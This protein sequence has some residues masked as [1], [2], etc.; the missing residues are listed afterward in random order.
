MNL[1]PEHAVIFSR[2]DSTYFG[3]TVQ[4][5]TSKLAGEFGR[6]IVGAPKSNSTY[7]QK[8]NTPGAVFTCQLSSRN[9]E[10][11]RFNLNENVYSSTKDDAFFGGSIDVH[12]EKN[13]LLACAPRRLIE[14]K[15][16]PGLHGIC[17]LVRNSEDL[18]ET[19]AIFT[20]FITENI[21]NFTIQGEQN[22]IFGMLSSAGNVIKINTDNNKIT[23]PSAKA[24]NIIRD[25]Y[26]GYTV[27]SAKL[28]ATDKIYFLSAAPRD[29][30]LKGK[31]IIFNNLQSNKAFR[32]VYELTGETTGEYFGSAMTVADVNGDSF[33][34]IIVGAPM[35][36][37]EHYEDRGR[38]YVFTNKNLIQNKLV[39]DRSKIQGLDQGS[40]FGMAISSLGDIN[41][42]GFE[43]IVVGAPYYND[44]RGVIYVYLGSK[45]GLS[46]DYKQRILGS[47]IDPGLRGFGYSLSR[48]TDIDN[49][50]YN[51][52]AVG[53]YLS[54]H[55]VLLKSL[56]I[57]I[58]NI[59]LKLHPNHK[60]ITV[61]SREIKIKCCLRYN[62]TKKPETLNVEVFINTQSSAISFGGSET[63]TKEIQYN[64]N[65]EKCVDV[66]VTVKEA[67]SVPFS[68]RYKIIN[69]TAPDR[70]CS[71]CPITD[72]RSKTTATLTVPFANGCADD[73]NCRPDLKITSNFIGVES[74]LV[75]GTKDKIDVLINISNTGEN[76]FLAKLDILHSQGINLLKTPNGCSKEGVYHLLCNSWNVIPRD[77]TESLNLLLDISEIKS[78]DKLFLKMEVL[79]S[80]NDNDLTNNMAYVEL[81]L[82]TVANLSLLG[83]SFPEEIILNQDG[84]ELYSIE[85]KYDIKNIG[86][87][88]LEFD[89]VFFVPSIFNDEI[90][91]NVLE[92][93]RCIIISDTYSRRKRSEINDNNT[94][95]RQENICD[96][97]KNCIKIQCS[98]F[99]TQSRSIQKTIILNVN[100]NL[101][102]KLRQDNDFVIHSSVQLESRFFDKKYTKRVRTIFKNPPVAANLGLKIA[103]A[104]LSGIIG[105]AILIFILYKMKFFERKKFEDQTAAETEELIDKQE[106]SVTEEIVHDNEKELVE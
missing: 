13:N 9:C 72:N 79:S 26:F 29:E 76:A 27:T 61:D 83:N 104:V 50:Y 78:V 74:E 12:N 32:K 25:S 106:P 41:K 38:I 24:N 19:P 93:E 89:L 58:I 4:L 77:K 98:A 23:I 71:T 35:Y 15:N 21:S 91:I 33:N 20:P 34:D 55:V 2:K 57:A 85:H 97:L 6:L 49:N 48:G 28:D 37:E 67:K 84:T 68:M 52:L 44:N 11:F 95:I 64:N 73:N 45:N 56:P 54:G 82:K 7:D 47:D 1:F 43:D 30:N 8:F 18:N 100:A 51:D 80:G 60:V 62:V 17:Y 70:F 16:M 10:Q 59:S 14:T 42:D 105:L 63:W 102:D 101:V 81:P 90:L 99:L 22:A 46:M 92:P 31:I 36:S 39:F 87:S 40:R 53:A 65:K 96:N 66:D 86:P 75:I 88:P 5:Q 94:N 103:V 3:Y 69:N